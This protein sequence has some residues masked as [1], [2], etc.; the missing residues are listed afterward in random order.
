MH[1]LPPTRFKVTA[2]GSNIKGIFEQT[3]R[4]NIFFIF[5]FPFTVLPLS[6]PARPVSSVQPVCFHDDYYGYHHYLAQ[7]HGTLQGGGT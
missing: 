5:A 7:L 6:A 4:H 3:E 1:C 2:A